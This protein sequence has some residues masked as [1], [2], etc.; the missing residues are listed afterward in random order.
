MFKVRA[1]AIADMTKFSESTN[2][3]LTVTKVN[4]IV[5]GGDGA[6]Y[7]EDFGF[8]TEDHKWC[9]TITGIVDQ[10]YTA[11]IVDITPGRP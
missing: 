7:T 8:G 5:T 2:I 4:I 9:I 3:I 1:T 10:R 6:K 11:E